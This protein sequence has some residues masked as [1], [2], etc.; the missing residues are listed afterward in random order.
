MREPY[1]SGVPRKSAG[2]QRFHDGLPVADFASSGVHDVGAAAH[3][4]EKLGVEQALGFRVERAVDRH[5]IHLSRT[6][7]CGFNKQVGGAGGG[8]EGVGGYLTTYNHE[9]TISK[10]GLTCDTG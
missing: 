3:S 8:L 10:M 4:G 6:E 1:I 9:Q 5:H 7:P 2:S